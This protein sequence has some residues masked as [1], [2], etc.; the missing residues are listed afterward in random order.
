MQS[1]LKTKEEIKE[2]LA[3]QSTESI[4]E[5]I[6]ASKKH[7]SEVNRLICYANRELKRRKKNRE[8]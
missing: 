6:E 3:A 8:V 2:L 7:A 4:K 5:L 1:T